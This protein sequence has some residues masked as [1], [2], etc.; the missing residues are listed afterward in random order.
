L[1][2]EKR[3]LDA[4]THTTLLALRCLEQL[5]SFY[6]GYSVSL[7]SEIASLISTIAYIVHMLRSE[8]QTTSMLREDNSEPLDTQFAPLEKATKGEE[9]NVKELKNSLAKAI[10]STQDKLN[11]T[12]ELDKILSNARLVL[13]EDSFQP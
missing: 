13:L 12:G 9:V 4:Q 6:R 8:T 1:R 11:C 3:N 2:S 10:E 7:R 5:A